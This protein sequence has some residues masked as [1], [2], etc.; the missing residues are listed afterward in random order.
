MLSALV[1]PVLVSITGIALP[2]GW[3]LAPAAWD[4]AAM[5]ALAQHPLAKLLLLAVISLFMWHGC[6]RLLH[7]L[8]DLGVHTGRAAA[9]VFYGLAV[10]VTLATAACLLFIGCECLLHALAGF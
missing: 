3:L 8:H 9:V 2:L 6:H 1:A 5:L 10:L 7:N 4:H